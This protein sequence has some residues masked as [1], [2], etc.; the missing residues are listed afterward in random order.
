MTIKEIRG[1]NNEELEELIQNTD[2]EFNIN[3]KETYRL[4]NLSNLLKTVKLEKKYNLPKDY[5][6]KIFVLNDKKFKNL[7]L[8][9]ECGGKAFAGK[10]EGGIAKKHNLIKIS[11]LKNMVWED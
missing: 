7:T 3:L 1:L 5:F 11:D 10:K 9:G 4:T 2:K 6:H 8:I